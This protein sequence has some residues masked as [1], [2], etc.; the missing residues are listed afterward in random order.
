MASQ[1]QMIGGCKAET[2][3]GIS[4]RFIILFQ[5]LMG[6]VERLRI[7]TANRHHTIKPKYCNVA[8][9]DLLAKFGVEKFDR[10]GAGRSRPCWTRRLTR[11]WY[12]SWLIRVNNAPPPIRAHNLCV[13]LSIH[14]TCRVLDG[15]LW[16]LLSRVTI[17]RHCSHIA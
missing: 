17:K 9:K 1:S 14:H 15:H 11:R 12:L 4:S 13:A 2:G 16:V 10:R 6:P 3:I 5:C 8:I 7:G